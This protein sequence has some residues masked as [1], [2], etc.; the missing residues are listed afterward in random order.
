MKKPMELNELETVILTQLL[1]MDLMG[2]DQREVIEL[3]GIDNM[4]KAVEKIQGLDFEDVTFEEQEKV[5]AQLLTKLYSQL[6][7]ID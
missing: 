1:L 6:G 4:K 3:A 5:T 7:I 2:K